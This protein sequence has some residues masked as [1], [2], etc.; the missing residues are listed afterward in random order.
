MALAIITRLDVEGD[1][2]HVE[3]DT[4]TNPYYR[5]HLGTEVR[6]DDGYLEPGWSTELL[7]NPAAGRHLDTR[8]RHVVDGSALDGL[9]GTGG[10][11]LLQVE[12]V[13]DPGGRGRALSPAV[14]V[15]LARRRRPREGHAMS[16]SL[17]VPAP[18]GAAHTLARSAAPVLQPPRIVDVRSARETFSRPAS[19]SDLLGLLVRA[20]V[21][22][23]EQMLAQSA[24]GSGAAG[25]AGAAR[26]AAG[27]T[28]DLGALLA[29]LLRSALATP[30]ST[31]PATLVMRDSREPGAALGNRLARPMI[32]GVDDALLAAL[33]GPA[34][35]GVV[36][37]LVGML[38]QLLNEANDKRHEEREDN[39]RLVT[40]LLAQVDRTRL[41]QQ[42]LDAQS[43]GS[44]PAASSAELEALTRLL[45]S[46]TV[47]TATTPPTA[48]APAPAAPARPPATPTPAAGVTTPAPASAAPVP[49]TAA[50]TPA[51]PS[52]AAPSA[53]GTPAPSA[54]GT[55]AP[56]PV[57][58]AAPAPAPAP[59]AAPAPARTQSRTTRAMGR[60]GPVASRAALVPVLGPTIPWQGQTRAAFARDR[61]I[62]LRYRLDTGA[63]GPAT[64]LPRAL[65]TVT[66]TA[67]GAP[68]LTRTERV[69]DLAPGAEVGISLTP[70]DLAAVPSHTPVEVSA[71]LRWPGRRGTYQCGC[72]QTLLLVAGRTVSARGERVGE[73]VE[74]TDMTRFRPFWNKV[75]SSPEPT[76][77]RPLWG[78]DLTLRYTV[79]VTDADSNG[80]METRHRDEPTESDHTSLR[81]VARGRLKSGIE[82]SV[83]ELA[84]LLPLWS[85]A[86]PV[87]EETLAALGSAAWRA[88]QGGDTTVT[89]RL[90]GR[91]SS[92]GALWVVPVPALRRFTVSSVAETDPHGQVVSTR[93]ETLLFP[94]V[95]S[96]RVI[97][98]V[99]SDDSG[100]AETV[101]DEG[102]GASGYAFA[103]H[104]TAL[105]L[106]VGLEPAVPAGASH[107]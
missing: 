81:A 107:G 2:L 76:P 32:F 63:D 52:G 70:E 7:R 3:V 14:R 69:V 84:A 77:E 102:A 82:V 106:L 78:V 5:I 71:Q 94:V 74:L 65:L 18:R 72:A 66:A 9:G 85:D 79:V 96:V 45:Q 10:P 67:A 26:P 47:P 95:E 36:G 37:P 46:G 51:A 24:A 16:T 23:V 93:D 98:L 58:A 91:R 12:S 55:L 89:V 39:R 86:G 6:R 19:V 11:I 15:P 53:S 35:S 28:A 29:G 49:A 60:P 13:K 20:A 41:L 4:G 97:G 83:R 31:G 92:S 25:A 87:D 27:G 61:V 1:A 80:L 101:P 44:A 100:P 40:E 105:D 59:A 104:E 103:G 54:S 43:A 33:A 48:P 88:T 50:P 68:V 64:P 90:E 30:A 22:V 57:S 73:P 56:A 42:L 34:L 38:P 75:W 62:R 17:S 8:A 21:P 99:S